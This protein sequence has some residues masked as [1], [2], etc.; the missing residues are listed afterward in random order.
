[1]PQIKK[2]LVKKLLEYLDTHPVTLKPSELL[3]AAE[4]DNGQG[5]QA[6]IM[7]IDD[8]YKKY[9]R[10]PNLP[11]QNAYAMVSSYPGAQL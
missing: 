1:M 6:G 11:Q 3:Y 4:K 5:I 9:V 8:Y 2:P 7:S 10:G